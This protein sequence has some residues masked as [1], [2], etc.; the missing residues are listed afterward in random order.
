MDQHELFRDCVFFGADERKIFAQVSH[1]FL[2][3]KKEETK[4]YMV[5]QDFQ[6]NKNIYLQPL[7]R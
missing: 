5:L 4:N 7:L 2:L 1:E 3:L 6:L